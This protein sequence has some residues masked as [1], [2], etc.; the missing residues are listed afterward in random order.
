MTHD[1]KLKTK[2]LLVAI[3]LGFYLFPFRTESSSPT[4]P[5]VLHP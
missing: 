3:A 5:M 1:P 4:A 2:E